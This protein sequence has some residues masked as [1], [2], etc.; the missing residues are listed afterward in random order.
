MF[1][2]SPEYIKRR[3]TPFSPP[4]ITWKE[5]RAVIPPELFRKST[6]RGMV[7]FVKDVA[8]V[9]ILF[10]LGQR[11]DGFAAE[12]AVARELTPGVASVLKWTLWSAY[13]YAQS[14]AMAGCWCL[15]HEAGHQNVSPYGV[16]NDTVGYILHTALLTPYFAWKRSHHTH[17][18]TVGSIERDENYVPRTKSEL[19]ITTKEQLH[20]M[21]EETPLYTLVRMCVMQ[22]L[23]FQVYLLF[24]TL[25][26]PHDPAGTNHFSPYSV[27]F[28]PEDFWNIVLS[29]AGLVVTS[30]L[31]I[32]YGMQV[33]AANLFKQY[34]FPYLLCHHWIVMLTYLHHSDPTLPHYRKGQ[35]TFLRG[36]LAT[37]D[38]PL[39]GYIG[40]LYFHNVSHDHIGHHLFTSIPYYN[41]PEVTKRIKAV[42]GVH[43]N[44]DNTNTFYAL[45]RSFTTCCY[46]EDEGDVVMYSNGKGETMREV[47]QDPGNRRESDAI[48]D[49]LTSL[50]T[51]G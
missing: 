42:L 12:V 48:P 33:G 7:S 21:F 15:G 16:V 5:L 47:V 29:D 36:C 50:H 24:N 28:K 35:W 34:I 40:R 41:Q 22:L 46:I 44:G 25:G 39:L 27:L 10:A 14:I 13:W 23:G 8:S 37:V 18:K 26:S 30:S 11:I 4:T 1:T 31:L 38:R 45:Y 43:Y 9:V 20:E 32:K 2:E 49:M 51:A 17:H 19:G 6:F 3:N